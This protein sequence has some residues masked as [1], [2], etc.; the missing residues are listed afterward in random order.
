M[1]QRA[2]VGRRLLSNSL[3]LFGGKVASLAT[4]FL[5]WLL[6]ARVAEA[7]EV[8]LA[9]GIVAAMMLA[10]QLAVAG[11]GYSVI[12]ER[13]RHAGDLP[14]LLDGAFTLVVVTAVAAALTALLVLGLGSDQLGEVATDVVF[15]L[16]FVAM[17][18]LGTVT[19]L[20]DHVS[21]ALERGSHVVVR[22]VASGAVTALPLAAALL[23]DRSLGARELFLLW[24]VGGIVAC[25][26]G[27]LQV[28]R[29]LPRYRYRPRL[30]P[31]LAARLLRVGLPNHALT[32]VE[33][34]PNLLLPVIVTE[35]LS[36]EQ[37]A[38]WYVSWMIAWAAL[39]V[40]VSVGIS[41]LAQVA[42]DVVVR[43]A[44]VRRGLRTGL[45]LA[46]PVALAVGLTGPWVLELMGRGYAAAG[47]APLR[48]LLVAVVPAL[49]VQVYYSLCR[50]SGRLP[51][52]LAAGLIA[53]AVSVGACAVAAGEHGLVGTAWAFVGVQ[54]LAAVWAGGRLASILRLER[55]AGPVRPLADVRA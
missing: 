37:N 16:L 42:Q 7:R 49:V 26:V 47:T 15:A 40:P 38:Y 12:L 3:G 28:S 50:S 25:L 14:R 24:V 36:P 48:I 45:G 8:G 52:A 39:Y 29:V 13:P 20:L 18:V 19:I 32:L 17:V 10:T 43:A 11:T 33:R 46:V 44:G 21:V 23:L 41:L 54:V 30:A 35:V 51:E 27:F 53:G 5:F 1:A 2:A 4:G 9:A 31:P 22:N 34:T 6:A 55:R